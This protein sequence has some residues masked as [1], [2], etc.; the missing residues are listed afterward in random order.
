MKPKECFNKFFFKEQY[1]SDDYTTH[2]IYI[3][4][5]VVFLFVP[6]FLSVEAKETVLIFGLKMPGFCFLKEYCGIE[7]PGCG[8][9]RSFVMLTHGRFAE[10]LR[11]HYVGFILYVFFFTQL[12]Y[13]IYCLK[14][15]GEELP[16]FLKNYQHYTPM[17]IIFMLILNWV[18]FK[19]H[20]F[21]L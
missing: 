9:T 16:V 3:V 10:A 5:F 8:L 20:L 7:C 21:H 17:V 2:V 6:F 1:V 12:L 13:R 19:S 11:F 18:V 4:I 14:H 15:V